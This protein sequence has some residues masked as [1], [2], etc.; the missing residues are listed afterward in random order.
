MIS[1]DKLQVDAANILFQDPLASRKLGAMGGQD[2]NSPLQG[3]DSSS[4]ILSVDKTQKILQTELVG[5]LEERFKQEGIELKGLNSD[6]FTPDKV[7]GRILG[8]IEMGIARAGDDE[9]KQSLLEQA[10][11]GV[12]QGFKEA[13]DIL[14]AIGVLNGK[15][16]EDIDKTYELIQ[17]GFDKLGK[18]I[19]DENDPEEDD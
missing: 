7:A 11:E 12:E 15:V 16:K 1:V 17:A 3:L 10:R 4:G 5:K 6:D 14:E 18:P 13:K 2:K 19:V 9:E 8:F